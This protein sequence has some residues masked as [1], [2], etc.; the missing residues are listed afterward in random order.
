MK[1]KIFIFLIVLIFLVGCT[2]KDDNDKSNEQDQPD[3]EEKILLIDTPI[4]NKNLTFDLSLGGYAKTKLNVNVDYNNFLEDNTVFN[5]D[6]AL[7]GTTLCIDLGSGWSA[8]IEGNEYGIVSPKTEIYELLGFMDPKVIELKYNKYEV[9]KNDVSRF[10]LANY[11]FVKNGERYNVVVVN[12]CMTGSDDEWSSNFDVGCDCDNYYAINGSEHLDWKNKENHKGFDVTA[13]RVLSYVYGYVAEHNSDNTIMFV[14]GYSRGAA[15]ANIIANDL[16]KENKYKVFAY[17]Y[18]TPSTVCTYNDTVTGNENIFNIYS[19]DDIVARVPLTLWGF[20]KYGIDICEK[21]NADLFKE[22]SGS[23]YSA[24]DLTKFNNLYLLQG[25]RSDIYS[26]EVVLYRQSDVANADLEMATEYHE[27]FSKIIKNIN[28]PGSMIISDVEC[29]N[30]EK[31]YYDFT[32]KGTMSSLI[33]IVQYL[34]VEEDISSMD[35]VEIL[36]YVMMVCY[37]APLVSDVLGML[38]FS[39]DFEKI[40]CPHLILSTIVIIKEFNK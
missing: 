30:E 4:F 3:E 27:K 29:V 17:T 10:A 23:S 21:V 28:K 15:V 33:D 7:L 11:P 34:M 36:D 14:T 35:L 6:L 9:D 37:Y 26:K 5:Q 24:V 25:T 40:A 13:N 39:M 32:I 38:G 8:K 18:E 19:D 16:N 31:G 1:K 20:K 2:P 22:M 12:V